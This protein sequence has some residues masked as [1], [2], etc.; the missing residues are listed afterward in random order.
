[1]NTHPIIIG[2]GTPRGSRSLRLGTALA[3]LMVTAAAVPAFAQAVVNSGFET[4]DTTGWTTEGGYWSS[5]W[6]VPASQYQGIP[7]HL[8]SVMSAGT[9]DAVTGAPTVFAGNY[10][11]RLNDQFGG[12]DISAI[13]QTVTGYGGNKLYYAWNAVLEP[14][15]GATDSPS[16]LI[17]VTDLTTNTVVTN[18]AY[19][20]FTAQNA[21][22]FRTA[23]NFVTTDWKV[24]NIDVIS[25]H[26]YK[27]VFV[28]V[29]CLYG[30][31]GGY[32]YVDGFGN[33]IPVP[34]A[35]V[36]FNPL[37]DVV[38]GGSI[39]IPISG[40]PDIDTAKAFYTTTEL[41]GAL[42]NPNFVGGT[43]QVDSGGPITNAFTVQSQGGTIDTNGNN[44]EFSGAFSGA[45][46]LAK[47]GLGTL[48]LSNANTLNGSVAVNAGALNVT[49]ALSAS[50]VNV[51]AGGTLTGNGPVI[52]AVNVNSGGILAPGVG[53]GALSVVADPVTMNAGSSLALDIDGRTYN[54]AG[55]AGSYDR[56]VLSSGG[57]FVA[58]GA[59]APVLRGI[60]PPANNTFVPVL[61]D[62]FTVVSGGPVTGA[63]ASVT[64]P[65]TG[66]SAN[67]RF[68][69]LYAPTSVTL[70][71]TPGSFATLGTAQ[72]W[73]KNAI[74]AGGGLDLVRP[75]PGSRNGPLQSLFDGLYGFD[76]AGYYNALT[77]LSGEIH[78]HDMQAARASAQHTQDD[79]I[80]A[81]GTTFGTSCDDDPQHRTSERRATDCESRRPAIWTR[82][83]HQD[84]TLKADSVSTGFSTK[85]DGFVAGMHL[86]N[87]S[88]FRFGVGGRY[89]ETKIRTQIGSSARLNGYSLFAYASH[90]FGALDLTAYLGWNSADVTTSRTQTLTSG[91]SLSTGNYRVT[92]TEATLQARYKIALGDHAVVRPVVGVSYDRT[93]ADAS[94]EYSPVP[95]TALT[96]PR[97]SWSTWQSKVGLEAAFGLGA[98]TVNARGNWLHTL[99][100]TPT[101]SRLVT[102]GAANWQVT[103]VGIKDDVAEFGGGLA[104]AISPRVKLRVDYSGIRDGGNYKADRISGGLS[105]A[106]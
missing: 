73:R 20:A 31:H 1:M 79:A 40:T 74:S 78:V 103:S 91:A 95:N 67:T 33:A 99:D 42:V 23:G 102:L 12:N 62:M 60:A 27:M 105:V 83:I 14:S 25:G 50:S 41:A 2:G 66:L 57:S 49:G 13:S 68:D 28:A 46:G 94:T 93:V 51:N 19:S 18:I 77:Q 92:G 88:D 98:V 59:I 69:V 106:F 89:S 71:L 86:I 53:I 85:E 36:A 81:A 87:R 101:A 7:A 61:G 47:A 10:S 21:S 5:G 15:H 97:K 65:A 3:A 70:V 29:D 11:L 38:Q 100:G 54:P 34:N 48:T 55:G 56:L 96:L 9:F 58:G 37:T 44:V 45:G 52:A 17:K 90:D 43:L 64:Q 24:E 4:G 39:L 22:I 75:A 82:L 35:G 6:P 104:L 84:S 30:G 63:F 72:N 80:D 16:F 76:A 32:V 8:I 26:D